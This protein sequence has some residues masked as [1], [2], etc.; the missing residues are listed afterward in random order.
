MFR[1]LFA[2]AA[3]AS[4]S[5]L[6]ACTPGEQ[7]SQAGSAIAPQAPRAGLLARMMPDKDCGG[8]GGVTVTP[9]PI[10]LT[11]HT[12]R[13]IVVTVSGP[14][15][16][17]SYLGHITSCFSGQ[18]CYNA[19]RKGSNQTKWRISSGQYCSAADV[20]FLG[21]NASGAEVGYFFL[22]VTNKYCP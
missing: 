18:I 14:G 6:A 19:E 15:V 4:L 3:V 2:A 12:K 11:K 21:V 22:K 16:V 5:I 1:R 20:E 10:R 13:G 8:V 17:N 7:V 9:C